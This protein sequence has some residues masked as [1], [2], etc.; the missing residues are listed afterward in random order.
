MVWLP[1]NTNSRLG[2]PS[3][4]EGLPVNSQIPQARHVSADANGRSTLPYGETPAR[5]APLCKRL[6]LQTLSPQKYSFI[7]SC[8]NRGSRADVMRPLGPPTSVILLGL[9]NCGVLNALNTSQR[10]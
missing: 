9:R 6:V 8:I 10:N 4:S 1:G 5:F 3:R 7:A 2:S